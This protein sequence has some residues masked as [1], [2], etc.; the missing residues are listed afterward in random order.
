MK[1]PDTLGT[2]TLV[3]PTGVTGFAQPVEP[4]NSVFHEVVATS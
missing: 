3:Q 2:A 1:V 4:V